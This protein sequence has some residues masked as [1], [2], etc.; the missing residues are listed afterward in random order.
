ML[1][2]VDRQDV[3]ALRGRARARGLG[4]T[5]RFGAESCGSRPNPRRLGGQRQPG[6][7][8]RDAHDSFSLVRVRKSSASTP[9][10]Q[11]SSTPRSPGLPA[12]ITHDAPR[13]AEGG[14]QVGAPLGVR[15]VG[16]GEAGD[17][18]AVV[19]REHLLDAVGRP[20]E[21]DGDAAGGEQVGGERRAG[22]VG[23]DG[24]HGREE[25]RRGRRLVAQRL[26]RR[27]VAAHAARAGAARRSG[28][29][30]PRCGNS[31]TPVSGRLRRA[32][33]ASRRAATSSI[34]AAQ[35]AV[36]EGGRDAAGLL[37]P[38]ELRPPGRGQVVGELLDGVRAAGRVGDPGD[39]GLGDQQRGGVARDP[40]AERVGHAERG[41]ERQH[42]D[43]VRSPDAGG[44]GGDGGAEHVHPRVVL[45]H[46]RPAG[47]DVLALLAAARPRSARARAPRAGARRAAWR[48]S[49]T[50]R[51]W[52]RTGTRSGRPRR[53]AGCRRR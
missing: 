6:E 15:R 7:A 17:R 14:H 49:G 5:A 52:R 29:V 20:G 26:E 12:T 10:A 34:R 42:G 19:R 25:D 53:R 8:L 24:A 51:R 43:R 33:S 1:G 13:L 18:L 27:G 46:H 11:E 50:A 44:E 32:I 41:V 31:L 48:W 30:S 4:R 35:R 40:A 37:D 39:V 28:S 22:G 47:D 21:V 2:A 36:V 38:A 3:D 16:A 9:I 23:G 45:A